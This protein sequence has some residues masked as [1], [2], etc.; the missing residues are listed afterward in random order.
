MN[1]FFSYDI[2]CVTHFAGGGCNQYPVIYIFIVFFTLQRI[3]GVHAYTLFKYKVEFFPH[4]IH[5]YVMPYTLPFKS[6]TLIRFSIMLRNYAC[7]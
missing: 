5:L 3:L 2:S 4:I 7:I 6:L 1:D